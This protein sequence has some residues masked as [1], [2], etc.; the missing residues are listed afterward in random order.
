MKKLFTKHVGTMYTYEYF[1]LF[2]GDT[3]FVVITCNGQLDFHQ[4][5]CCCTQRN[6]IG[7]KIK[8]NKAGL[9]RLVMCGTDS[10]FN[11]ELRVDATFNDLTETEVAEIK[12]FVETSFKGVSV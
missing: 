9:K 1:L 3:G 5:M 12:A 4:C 11:G 7:Q 10:R 6:E 2:R 8:E